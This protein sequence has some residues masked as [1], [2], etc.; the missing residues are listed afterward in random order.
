MQAQ[1][2]TLCGKSK[3]LALPTNIALPERVGFKNHLASRTLRTSSLIQ[4]SIKKNLHPTYE[5]E[6]IATV[7]LVSKHCFISD[8]VFILVTIYCDGGNMEP[9]LIFLTPVTAHE[10]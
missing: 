7:C 5:T 10:A 2:F 6:I 9:F 4:A 8:C 3:R 1:S